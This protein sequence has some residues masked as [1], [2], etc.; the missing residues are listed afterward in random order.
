MLLWVLCKTMNFRI[1]DTPQNRKLIF[2]VIKQL[3]IRHLEQQSEKAKACL[4]KCFNILIL[5]KSRGLPVGTIRIWGGV[6]FIK[7]PDK[8]WVRYYEKETRGAKKSASNLKKKISAC[9][10]AD[11]MMQLVL[12]NR[13]RFSDE[14]G[15]PLPCV[16]HLI[17]FIEETQTSRTQKQEVET[18]K[19]AENLLQL[20]KS[21]EPIITRELKTIVKQNNG[22]LTG[23]EHKL[24]G[25]DSLIRKIMADANK[26][27]ISVEAAANSITDVLRYTVVY[28]EKKYT[29]SYFK[30]KKALE[31]I[32]YKTIRVKNTFKDDVTYKGINTLVKD[33]NGNIF[34]L[35]YHTPRS[36]QVK[37]VELHKLYEEFR[38]TKNTKR[39]SE[40][41]KLMKDLCKTIPNPENVVKI[42]NMEMKL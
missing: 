23:L 36:I 34:E 17:K 18:S 35:Q 24:K 4:E 15:C 12:L 14:K 25:K 32:G 28:D 26:K 5:K 19:I 42:L 30:T 8:K 1:K 29:Q 41:K 7:R 40:L 16:Q 9:K 13:N 39:M 6:K 2:S 37:E 3:L 10:T 21:V 22:Y 20:K 11:E 38:I 31:N 27:N 33:N